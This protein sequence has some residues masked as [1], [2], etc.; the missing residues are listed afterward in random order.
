[1]GTL[2]LW[3]IIF[4][5]YISD[6][7]VWLRAVRHDHGGDGERDLLLGFEE[8]NRFLETRRKQSQFGRSHHQTLDQRQGKL[9]NELYTG[10]EKNIHGD[11]LVVV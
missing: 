5:F 3:R 7:V 8:K 1:M 9:N 4:H 2:K 6:V 11:V 10:N